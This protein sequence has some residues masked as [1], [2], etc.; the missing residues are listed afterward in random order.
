[1]SKRGC[2]L[3]YDNPQITHKHERVICPA[4]LINYPW[5]VS[6]H[7][8]IN[9]LYHLPTETKYASDQL[10][11]ILSWLLLKVFS[12]SDSS[13]LVPWLYVSLLEVC[14]PFCVKYTSR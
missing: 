7:T 11:G 2:Y 13:K 10:S 12:D 6:R 3:I 1:M 9:A 4:G 14:A 5:L 8:R